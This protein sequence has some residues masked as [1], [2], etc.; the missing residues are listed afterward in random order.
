MTDQ[1]FAIGCKEALVVLSKLNDAD[2]S[3]I[4]PIAIEFLKNNAA[5]NYNF[6]LDPNLTLNEQ[7]LSE[8]SRSL[9]SLLY[10]N[11]FVSYEEKLEIRK[12]DLDEIEKRKNK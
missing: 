6:E 4:N 2:K 11:T 1:E 5:P 10:R 3:R 7:N 8:V 9:L 12:R